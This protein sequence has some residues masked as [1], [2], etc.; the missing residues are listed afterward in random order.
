[1]EK[2]EMSVIL[3]DWKSLHQTQSKGCRDYLMFPPGSRSMTLRS[4][5]SERLAAMSS[6]S[7]AC[8]LRQPSGQLELPQISDLETR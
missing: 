7:T 1:M 6:A 2:F 3:V 8:A 5:H 4:M